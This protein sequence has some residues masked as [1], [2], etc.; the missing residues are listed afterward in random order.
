[1]TDTL[2]FAGINF[3]FLVVGYLMGQGQLKEKVQQIIKAR[4]RIGTGG[5][6][7]PLEPAELNKKRGREIL[8]KYQQ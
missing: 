2:I 5:V 1:M 3:I 8:E 4:N 6:V 7:T